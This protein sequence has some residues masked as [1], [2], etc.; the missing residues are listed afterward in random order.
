MKPTVCLNM[1][2]K[3]E[4]H[5]I[6]KTLLNLM[7]YIAFD[8]WVIC[9]TGS[10]DETP[11]IIQNFFKERNINGE[12]VHHEWKDFA[13]NRTLALECAFNKTDYVFIFDADDSI[14]GTFQLPTPMNADWYMLQFGHGVSYTRPL[15]FTNHKRWKFRGV[16]HEYL[17]PIDTIGQVVTLVGNYH[18]DSG[19]SGNRS[20]QPDKYYKDALVLEKAFELEPP[21]GLKPRY[22]FYCAQSYKDAGD[23]YTDKAIEWYKKVLTYHHHWN[24]EHYYSSL[25]LGNLYKNKNDMPNSIYYYMKTV[26]YDSERI[27]GVASTMSHFQQTGNHAIVNALY[28][29]FKN[30]KQLPNKLFVNTYS[31]QHRIEYHNS[32]SAFYINDKQSGYDC[33]KHILLNKKLD[34][35][36]FHRTI[37][38]L[39]CFYKDQLEQDKDTLPLFYEVDKLPQ[40]WNNTVQELW[41]F[42][43]DKNRK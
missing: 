12:L 1:I 30:Y 36:D 25:Q 5:I 16:L 35:G 31:Y 34:E 41:N 23:K 8:Y 7:Q 43:F 10:S 17:E 28:H 11:S 13:H 3:D 19:R 26:E 38:N 32:I 37:Q 29:K 18:V 42:L 2:V 21:D 15:L 4:S 33:C 24:Q 9:D 40:P 27:E 20:L 6:E 22:S 39:M 14:H